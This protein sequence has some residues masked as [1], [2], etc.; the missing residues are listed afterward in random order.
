MGRARSELKH[1]STSTKLDVGCASKAAVTMR[2]TLYVQ[3]T[4]THAD[5]LAMP[6][7]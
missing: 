1:L 3:K 6:L 5:A 4:I 7:S 2:S